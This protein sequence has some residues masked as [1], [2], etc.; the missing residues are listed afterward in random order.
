MQIEQIHTAIEILR[1]EIPQW[2][3]ALID[4]MAVE[5]RNPYKILITTILSLRTKDTLTEKIAPK[6]FAVAD[7]PTAMLKLSAD[8]IVELIYPV[9]FYR[10]KSKS[11]LAIS[12]MLLDYHDGQVPDE[13]DTL[14]ALPGVGRKTANLVL[15][16][17]FGKP[18]ICVDIHVHRISNRWGYVETKTPE[19]TEFALRDKLPSEYWL[20]YNRLLVV[21]GQNLCTP[22]SPWCSKCKLTDLCD[23][24]G[25]TRTR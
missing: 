25:V 2:Q 5:A 11:I 10:N 19:K 23:Q 4:G 3:P 9:G 17:S 21:F 18:G 20:E 22:V 13:L 1:Q 16:S 12:Q 15:T 7:T 8:E 6:L 24:V 14:L